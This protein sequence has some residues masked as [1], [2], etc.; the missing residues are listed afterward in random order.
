VHAPIDTRLTT[1]NVTDPTNISIV[2]SITSAA[3]AST[4]PM[5]RAQSD[6]LVFAAYSSA[7]HAIDFSVPAVPVNL[8]NDPGSPVVGPKGVEMGDYV[9]STALAFAVVYTD[10]TTPSFPFTDYMSWPEVAPGSICRYSIYDILGGFS[11]G[12]S[13]HVV[14]VSVPT[15]TLRIG[16]LGATGM[17][18]EGQYS[19]CVFY[20]SWLIGVQSSATEIRLV[21]W[22]LSADLP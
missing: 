3:Y 20:G 22:D 10:I 21:A 14:D 8:G 19:G 5:H 9:I 2:A 12:G 13:A 16:N 4:G 1:V 11:N 7:T 18:G 6:P 17:A 15:G